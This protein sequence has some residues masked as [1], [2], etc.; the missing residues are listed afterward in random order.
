MTEVREDALFF[1]GASGSAMFGVLHYSA[2][3]PVTAVV[4]CNPFGEEKQNCYR[5]FVAFARYLARAGIPSFRFDYRGSG[6][7]GGESSDVT[8]A[9]QIADLND[10]IELAKSSFGIQNVVLVGLRLGAAVA[11]LTAE[12]KSGISALALLS[13]I[14]DGSVYWNGLLRKEQFASIAM[15][16][17]A[18]K[19]SEILE[20]LDETGLIEIEAQILNV[21]MVSQLMAVNLENSVS[22]FDGDVLIAGLSADEAGREPLQ[23]LL[24]RYGSIGCALESWFDEPQDYWSSRSM[25]DGYVPESTFVRVTEWIQQCSQH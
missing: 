8:I 18:R 2:E 1:E 5:P 4:F 23:R 6:D 15:G 11:A 12:K 22:R 25:Y 19:K 21:E 9:T 3:D 17:K 7:S 14:V 13:P 10:A 24:V 16:T 20:E